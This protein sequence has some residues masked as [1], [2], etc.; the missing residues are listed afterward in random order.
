MKKTL[1]VLAVVVIAGALAYARWRPVSAPTP[2]STES[3]NIKVLAPAPYAEITSPL[4]VSGEAR[5]F[6]QSYAY[7]LVDENGDMLVEGFG[8]ANATDIGIFGPFESTITFAKPQSAKRGVLEVFQYSANDG[9][10]IDK[11]S[12]PVVFK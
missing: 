9:S 1:I 10:E 3:A 8:T 2:I 12:I 11:V 5:T 6:E 7:R 4:I